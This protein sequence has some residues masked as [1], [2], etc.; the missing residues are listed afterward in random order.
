MSTKS[1]TILIVDDDPQIL[2]LV[3]K[4]VKPR[5]GVEILLAPLPSAALRIY[6][7]Q[8]VHVMISDVSMPEMD[9]I[10]LAERVLKLQPATQVLLISGQDPGRRSPK[11]PSV[12]FLQKP[13][14]PS[15]L[16]QLLKEML[17]ED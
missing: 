14:F 5:A 9:G 17:P 3:E 1:R 2:R 16:I 4:M 15:V 10:K 7:L 11:S 6:E 12:R 8:P 13:F